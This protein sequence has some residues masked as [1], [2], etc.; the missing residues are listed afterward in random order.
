MRKSE[1]FA[2]AL[3]FTEQRLEVAQI[4]QC[5]RD[6]VADGLKKTIQTWEESSKTLAKSI[7]DLLR[8]LAT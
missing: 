8:D 7:K 2:Q 3:I 1:I 6:Y 5:K 4:H